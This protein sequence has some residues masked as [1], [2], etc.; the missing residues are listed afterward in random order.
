MLLLSAATVGENL[1][2]GK[3]VLHVIME[4]YVEVN[5]VDTELYHVNLEWNT[6]LVETMKLEN[7]ISRTAQY[8]Y[9]GKECQES[10]KA[11]ELLGARRC[12]VD[13]AHALTLGHQ[14]WIHREMVAS[15]STPGTSGREC[16]RI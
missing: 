9:S 15:R 3:V 10:Q 7:L 14:E 1:H 6:D 12:A 13:E 11:Q 16:R 2:E 4:G 5:C 8:L